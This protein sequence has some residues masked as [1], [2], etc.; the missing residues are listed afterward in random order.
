MDCPFKQQLAEGSMVCDYG[1]IRH[2][3]GVEQCPT[4]IFNRCQGDDIDQV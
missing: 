3:P 4:E 1:G 2:G